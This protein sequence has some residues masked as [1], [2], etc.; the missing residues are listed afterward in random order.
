MLDFFLNIKGKKKRSLDFFN[1]IYKSRVNKLNDL[2]KKFGCD[3]GYFDGS[4]KYFT[5]KP[6]SYTDLYDFLFSFQS[7]NIKK[8]FELGIGTNKTF[9]EK[10]KRKSMPGA[11]LR[12][13]K[14]FFIN[15]KI[16]GADIDE[17]TLFEEDRIK[18]YIVDQFDASS[19]QKMWRKIKVKNFDLII[20]DG[21]HQY[22][23]T[24]NFFSNSV[25]FLRKN[26]FYIIE[27]IFYKDK[28]KYLRFFEQKKLNF[29]FVELS[30][31]NKM[32]DNNLLIIKK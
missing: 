17:E 30:S 31:L 12:V 29:F 18:T 25:K 5:W 27:D 22:K 2:C 28:E 19:V 3:K 20:D 8:V 11:S 1:F 4:E 6:H 24:I 26:G 10:L 16:Y 32:K 14:E 7:E 23:G 13:W 21:C 15:A 9:N